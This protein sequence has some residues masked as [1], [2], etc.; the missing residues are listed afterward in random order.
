[1]RERARQSDW[2]GVGNTGKN[3]CFAV[4]Q[5]VTHYETWGTTVT[6]YAPTW[7]YLSRAE[8]RAGAERYIADVRISDSSS[9]ATNFIDATIELVECAGVE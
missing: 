3:S 2:C 9:S 6:E 7:G 1:M 4:V 5:F 8:A